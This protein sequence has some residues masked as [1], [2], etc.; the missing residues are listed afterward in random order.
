[1][2]YLSNPNYAQLVRTTDLKNNFTNSNFIYI[3]EDSYNYL[4]RV[5]LDKPAIALSRVGNCG[6]VYY[7]EP[8]KL[9]YK[10]NALAKNAL[11]VRSSS[12]NLK[13]LKYIFETKFY[14]EQLN[15]II[16]P[17]GQSK[18]NKKD[19]EN[20]IIPLPTL[21]EQERIVSILDKFDKYCNDISE[22]LPV[23][24]KYRQ[25]QYEYYRD[26]LLTFKRLE[27]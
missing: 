26:K 18:F 3:S 8:S 2:P 7:I 9:P 24:I 15:K 16:S 19:F 23:E 11:L 17:V 20:I 13:F 14:L 4:W 6:E 21:E 27:D 12:N 1:M 25:Q 22:G 10:K 5:Q